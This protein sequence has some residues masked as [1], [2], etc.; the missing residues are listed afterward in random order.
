ML[1]DNCAVIN[2]VPDELPS[3][4]YSEMLNELEVVAALFGDTEELMRPVLQLAAM[5]HKN[6]E[7]Y[8]KL[9]CAL[10]WKIWEYHRDKLDELVRLYGYLWKAVHTWGINHFEGEDFEKYYDIID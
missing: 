2:C 5:Y 9:E 7:E 4:S 6:P 1:F 10:N 3:N 8:A